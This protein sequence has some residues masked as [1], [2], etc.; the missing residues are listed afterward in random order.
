M[1]TTCIN[2]KGE[3][4]IDGTLA[5]P[6]KLEKDDPKDRFSSKILHTDY[7]FLYKVISL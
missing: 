6:Y 7:T 2:E 4:A 5:V 3:L 1:S